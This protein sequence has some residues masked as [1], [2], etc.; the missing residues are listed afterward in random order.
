[1]I[2]VYKILTHEKPPRQYLNVHESQKE[3]LITEL[4]RTC[5]VVEIWHSVDILDEIREKAITK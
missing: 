4:L 5:D 1:M 2:T 3:Q